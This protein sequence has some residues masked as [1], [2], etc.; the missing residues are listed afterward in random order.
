VYRLIDTGV[1]GCCTGCVQVVGTGC[2]RL[3][4]Q[5][6]IVIG[7]GLLVTGCCDSD[8]LSTFGTYISGW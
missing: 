5:V 1:T 2:D 7:T 3:L 8:R 6:C 4:V